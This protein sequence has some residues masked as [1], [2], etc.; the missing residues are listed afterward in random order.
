MGSNVNREKL[1]STYIR[2]ITNLFKPYIMGSKSTISQESRPLKDSID[3]SSKE[4]F[5]KGRENTRFKETAAISP[6]TNKPSS[7]YDVF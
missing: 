2:D 7:K 5:Q 1:K 4:R 3:L 6:P